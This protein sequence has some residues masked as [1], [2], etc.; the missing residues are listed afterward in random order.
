[1]L[2]T[3]L[4]DLFPFVWEAQRVARNIKSTCGHAWRSVLGFGMP[5]APPEGRTHT[6]SSKLPF[7]PTPL[8][9]TPLETP[10]R[11]SQ[12]SPHTSPSA[13]SATQPGS[14][15]PWNSTSWLP[16]GFLANPNRGHPPRL[17]QPPQAGH[18]A[19]QSHASCTA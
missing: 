11:P 9:C 4:V 17:P 13:G 3:F 8:T 15:F 10:T 6:S 19:N 14:H 5:S 12:S 7:L 1:M 2:K 16:E 18:P